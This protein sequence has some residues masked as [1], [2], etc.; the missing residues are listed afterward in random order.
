MNITSFTGLKNRMC[1][2]NHPDLGNT[3]NSILAEG[4]KVGGV[5]GHPV[6]HGSSMVCAPATNATHSRE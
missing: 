3:D 4:F 5:E 6:Q 2:G 1:P